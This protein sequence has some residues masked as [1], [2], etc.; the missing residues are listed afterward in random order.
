MA[1]TNFALR[2]YIAEIVYY[3]PGLCGKTTTLEQ[4]EG[5][6]PGARLVRE[7]TEGERTVFFDLLPITVPLAGGWSLQYNVKTVPGQVQYVRA[8]QQNL[9]D[10]DAVVFVADSHYQRAEA[11]LVA[12]DD[13]RRTL[14]SNGRSILEVPVILQ[15]NKQDLPDI[16]G[17]DELQQRLNPLDW[18]A[19]ASI[20][21]ERRGILQPLGAAM[22]AAKSR[23]LG[24]IQAAPP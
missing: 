21:R 2:R 3:G 9:R 1:T 8:R 23:A 16:L 10:P 15:Y 18:P 14:E 4:I 11:N 24:L 12:M 20:A 7:D 13:L 6:L 5:Q 19:F 22:A 17:W